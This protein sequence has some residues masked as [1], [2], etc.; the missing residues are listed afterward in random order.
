MKYKY[1]PKTKD[2]LKEIIEKEIKIQGNNAD[3]NMID[4]N[5]SPLSR[6]IS[7]NFYIHGLCYFL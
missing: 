1:Q 2:E 4:I 3:L 6:S 5:C 7:K